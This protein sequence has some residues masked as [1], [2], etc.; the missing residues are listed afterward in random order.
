MKKKIAWKSG[1]LNVRG[2]VY[3]E[4]EAHLISDTKT[5][6]ETEDFFLYCKKEFF[7][8]DLLKRFWIRIGNPYELLHEAYYIKF[9]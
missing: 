5:T 3:H 7:I 2:K 6:L 9:R 4:W 8:I 1:K